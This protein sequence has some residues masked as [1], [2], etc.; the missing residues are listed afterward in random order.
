[1]SEVVVFGRKKKQ[2][3]LSNEAA[4]HVAAQIMG[5][6]LMDYPQGHVITADAVAQV[7]DLRVLEFANEALK[8]G[9][10]PAE[11]AAFSEFVRGVGAHLA[12][13][14]GTGGELEGTVNDLGAR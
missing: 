4:S 3:N 2:A 10:S 1:L 14:Y 7:T 11:I 8:A 5:R 12:A 13:A 6:L 9:K